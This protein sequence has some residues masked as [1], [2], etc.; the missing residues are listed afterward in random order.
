MTLSVVQ[1]AT[2]NAVR[3]RSVS[4]PRDT[5]AKETEPEAGEQR[6]YLAVSSFNPERYMDQKSFMGPPYTGNKQAL[7][8]LKIEDLITE[9]RHIIMSCNDCCLLLEMREKLIEAKKTLKQN[10]MPISTE[11]DTA[12]VDLENSYHRLI[13]SLKNFSIFFQSFS[14]TFL[15]VE[16]PTTLTKVLCDSALHKLTPEPSEIN[17]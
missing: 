7:I 10:S 6:D 11:L 8:H 12:I 17:L 16:I 9:A 2:I 13:L 15:K 4:P 14:K 5:Q 1:A 3:Q